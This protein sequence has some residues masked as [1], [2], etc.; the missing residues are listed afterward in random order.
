M[1]AKFLSFPDENHWV[2]RPGD[3]TVWYDT[4]F[5]FLDHHVLGKPWS[6]SSPAVSLSFEKPP[7]HREPSMPVQVG[8]ITVDCDDVLKVA[9]FWSEALGRP[10]DAGSSPG[11]ASIGGGDAERTIPAWYFA[12]VPESKAAKNRMHLD[13]VDPDPSAIDRLVALGAS[14]V[15]E[16]EIGDG[17]HRWTVMRDPEGNEF[18]L[19]AKTF[20]G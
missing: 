6:A 17:V 19:A 2:L 4:V 11:F 9:G 3:A 15:G 13:L 14:I 1:Q 8:N 5:A 10:L 20:T 16:H 7:H 18:C 12:Q